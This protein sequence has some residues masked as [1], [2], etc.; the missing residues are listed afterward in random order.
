[1][2]KLPYGQKLCKF[3][4]VPFQGFR[5]K[6]GPNGRYKETIISSAIA[7]ERNICQACL[8]DLQFGL[9][10]GMRDQLL[11]ENKMKSPIPVSDVGAMYRHQ[12]LLVNQ[13]KAEHEGL[14]TI[15][16]YVNMNNAA[17]ANEMIHFA[18]MIRAPD[19]R[20]DSSTAFRNLPQLCSFWLQGT[21][22][23]VKR[24]VCPYRPC[25]GTFLFPELASSHQQEMKALISDL[26]KR[27]ADG[28]QSNLTTEVR[29]LFMKKQKGRNRDEAIN[30]RI[31]GEDSLTEVYLRKM[32]SMVPLPS[33][34]P[35]SS[36]LPPSYHHLISLS[37]L[38]SLLL[39]ISPSRPFGWEA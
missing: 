30:K 10:V 18:N 28:V 17:A 33:L 38:S 12:E 1:M 5:W 15:P 22:K 14:N 32:K 19:R 24:G 25:C 39:L 2:V 27:G 36:T 20:D 35:P 29:E 37:D 16:D 31:S 13:A 23:R 3:G 21:C 9:P 26:E 4:K 7:K 8:N 34:P 6:A 11:A